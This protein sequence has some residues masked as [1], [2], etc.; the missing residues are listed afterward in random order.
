MLSVPPHGIISFTPE[1]NS[2]SNS[3]LIRVKVKNSF[4]NKQY[5]LNLVPVEHDVISNRVPVTVAWTVESSPDTQQKYKYSV[6]D[7]VNNYR[8]MQNNLY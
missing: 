3:K 8:Q 1:K 2:T 4:K 7:F 5:Q 6:A